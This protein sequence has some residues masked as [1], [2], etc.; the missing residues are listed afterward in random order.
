MTMSKNKGRFSATGMAETKEVLKKWDNE[1]AAEI[2]EEKQT[3]DLKVQKAKTVIINNQDDYENAVVI[4]K[5]IKKLRKRLDD[6]YKPIQQKTKEANQLAL[7]NIRDYEKPLSEAEQLIRSSMGKYAMK[8]EQE[9]KAE[10]N[11]LQKEAEEKERLKIKKE[12]AE[13]GLNKKEAKE[14]AE[15]IEVFV[16]IAQIKDT[17]KTNNVTYRLSWKYRVLDISK[18]PLEYMIENDPKIGSVVRALKKET[19]IRGIEVYSEKVPIIR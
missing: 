5:E 12:L 3:V 7:Q 19:N 17:T 9:R 14:E 1:I 6:R 8:K 15:K 16:P 13:C 2:N 11:R 4:I 10:E 18:I